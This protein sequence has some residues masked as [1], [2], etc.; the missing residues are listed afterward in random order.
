M[1]SRAV[2]LYLKGLGDAGDLE[3]GIYAPAARLEV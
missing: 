3:S 2:L 1:G